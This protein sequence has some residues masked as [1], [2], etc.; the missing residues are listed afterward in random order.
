M[1][2]PTDS[3]RSFGLGVFLAGVALAFACS[4]ASVSYDPDGVPDIS[5]T[6]DDQQTIRAKGLE[7]S[8]AEAEKARAKADLPA[9]RSPSICVA[10]GP[11]RTRVMSR[12]L[13]PA[14]AELWSGWSINDL[15]SWPMDSP[16]QAFRPCPIRSRHS[17]AEVNFL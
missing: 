14:R 6:G 16:V 7:N 2:I 9:P 11:A 1:K 13:S 15:W 17:D 12:V 5:V 3:T 4:D 8:V 10:L